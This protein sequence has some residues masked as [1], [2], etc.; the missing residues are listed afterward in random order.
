MNEGTEDKILIK[1]SKAGRGIA[2][3]IGNGLS[4]FVVEKDWWVVKSTDNYF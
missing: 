1:F 2:F 4:A 3:F